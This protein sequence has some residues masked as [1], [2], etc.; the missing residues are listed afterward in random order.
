MNDQTTYNLLPT[1]IEGVGPLAELA[2]D[3]RWSWNHAT[4]GLWRTLDP[5]LWD[6]TQNPWVVLQTVSRN[7]I[8]HVLADP[9]FSARTWMTAIRCSF[10]RSHRPQ[11]SH[12]TNRKALYSARRASVTSTCA[13][14][15]AGNMDAMIAATSSTMTEAITGHALGICSD[16]K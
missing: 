3:M 8:E 15:A 6:L 14:R 13:A 10:F 2:L 1:D 11:C 5:T 12:D 16:G 9:A 7:Q 4:D